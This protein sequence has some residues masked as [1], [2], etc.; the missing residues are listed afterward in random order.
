LTEKQFVA[1]MVRNGFIKDDSVLNGF[2]HPDLPEAMFM[3]TAIQASGYRGALKAALERLQKA[4]AHRAAAFM[5][6]A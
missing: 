4:Q 3:T 5:L 2:R 1:A 6:V